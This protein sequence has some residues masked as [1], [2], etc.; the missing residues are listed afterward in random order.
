[1]KCLSVGFL[2]ENLLK[3]DVLKLTIFQ[4]SS[5][6]FYNLQIILKNKQTQNKTKQ[7]SGIIM[8]KKQNFNQHLDLTADAELRY[9]SRLCS[10]VQ[11]TCLM[12]LPL[13]KHSKSYIIIQEQLYWFC[14]NFSSCESIFILKVLV[15]T[16]LFPTI[17]CEQGD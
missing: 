12:L 17:G 3:K 15:T 11:K 2:E 13:P 14:T 5:L 7:V 4:Q 1:M 16:V 8:K 6:F 10:L 9:K